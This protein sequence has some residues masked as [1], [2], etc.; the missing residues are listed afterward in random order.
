M[1][2]FLFVIMIFISVHLYAQDLLSRQAP[3]D[4]ITKTASISS[5]SINNDTPIKDYLVKNGVVIIDKNNGWEWLEDDESEYID[6]AYP[7]ELRYRKY[8]SHP[9]YKVID[10]DVFGNNG[11]I[12]RVSNIAYSKISYGELPDNIINELLRQE[13][14]KDY[15]SNKYN[16]M[17]ENAAAQM[18]VKRELGLIPDNLKKFKWSNV[19]I[20]Y[21]RQLE[22][23]HENDFRYLLK[24]ERLDNLSFKVTFGNGEREEISTYKITYSA[25]GKFSYYISTSKL[26]LESIDWSKYESI[27][28]SKSVS[29]YNGKYHEVRFHKVKKGETLQSIA[30]KRGMTVESLCKHNHIKKNTILRPGQ[31]LKYSSGM[32]L[33]RPS[34]TDD[35]EF[36]LSSE[37]IAMSVENPPADMVEESIETEELDVTKVYDV[38]E[39]MPSF[40]GGQGALMSWLSSNIKYPPVAEENGV[41]GRVVCSFVVERDGSISEVKV[42]KGVDPSLDKEAIRVLESMPKWI[43]GKQKGVAVKVKYTTPVTFRLQ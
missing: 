21:L 38:V 4:K 8:A 9:E 3:I 12:I 1:K 26:P 25:K 6:E 10:D 5:P 24:C 35:D 15:R 16:F 39:Q 37:S 27:E 28:D 22:M 17:K 13:Y 34:S 42:R 30:R 11:T 7:M 29:Y 36:Q 40:P 2:K 23:D 33:D 43:P 18:H 32:I 31:I 14:I 20:R 41:Q 19:A